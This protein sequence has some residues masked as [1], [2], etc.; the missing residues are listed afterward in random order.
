MHYGYLL[1]SFKENIMEALLLVGAGVVIALMSMMYRSGLK[2]GV[3]AR[4]RNIRIVRQTALDKAQREAAVWAWQQAIELSLAYHTASLRLVDSEGVATLMFEDIIVGTLVEGVWQIKE[5]RL[6]LLIAGEKASK[7]V[8]TPAP[9]AVN[10][11]SIDP[12]TT[13]WS[14]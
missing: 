11:W 2:A 5:R 14:A 9:V 4:V 8:P 13:E 12:A 6:A 7:Q 1:C 3:Q 10:D